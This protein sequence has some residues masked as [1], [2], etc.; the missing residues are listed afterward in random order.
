[1]KKIILVRYGEIILKGLNRPVFED[2]LVNNIKK[3]LY[4]YGKVDVIK[5]Q[6]RIFVEPLTD[7]YEFDAALERLT[8]VF[9]IV[10]VSPVW[11]IDTD[12]EEMKSRSL[13]LVRDLIS[14]KAAEGTLTFKVETK[15]G[16]KRF[17]MESPE[18]SMELGG[19]ILE[20]ITQLK[21]DV[22][23][24]SFILYVEVR[25]S[26]YIYSEIIPANGGMPIGT[27]GKAVLL[28]SGG[29]DSPVAGWM[30]AKRGVEIEAVH[31]YSYPYTSERAKDKV[32]ELTKILASYCGPI[33]LHVVP[34]TEIQL[35]INDK[36]PQDQ[37]TIIMRR[38]MM[39]ISERIAGSVGALA[40]ITGESVGQVASQT[41]QSLAV[42]NAVV[43]MPVFRPLIGMDKNEVITIARR[44]DT[45][46]T[47]I[48]PYEDC[49]TVFVAKHPKTKPQLDKILLSESHLDMEPLIERAINNTE[50]IKIYSKNK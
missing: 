24:P 47:S 48:L 4:P 22:H 29:I 13:E 33:N 21:V 19:Y 25:E 6:G 35:E 9:G 7:D 5:S 42:T 20:N 3:A 34:F 39:I 40:L 11:K 49:C 16:N 28:L 31:F 23:N 1:M 8:R 12:F 15:R 46:E 44:I 32:I 10:S 14:K 18:I 37:M 27:N 26:T 38:I 30:I 2:K 41:I 17:P 43:T 45:F 36:C 50:V